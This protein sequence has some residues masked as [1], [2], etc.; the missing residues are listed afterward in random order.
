LALAPVAGN[1][2]DLDQALRIAEARS[3]QL[4]AQRAAFQAA[5][6]LVPA[7]G[8]N[9]DPRLV[10]G[11]E[12]V[13]AD[14]PDRGSLTADFMT[15]RRVGVMQDFVRS[16]KREA[17]EARAS[18]EALREAAM[19]D[20]QRSDLYRDVATAWF[21]KYYADRARALLDALDG[22]A[23]LQASTTQAELAAGKMAAGEALGAKILIASLADRRAESERK[24]RRAAASL[25]RWIEAEPA[26]PIG[27]APDIFSLPHHILA[28]RADLSLHPHIAVYAPIEAAA[29]AELTLARAA[30]KPDW[31]VELSYAQRGS[32]YTNMVTLM[33]R[34]DLPLFGSRRQDPVTL[35]KSRQLEQVRAQ[36]DDALRKHAAEVRVAAGDWEIAKSRVERHR[37]EIVPLVEERA[38]LARAAYEGGR[39]DL[40]SV[41]DARRGAIEARLAALDAEA[42]L[43]RAWAQ[44][45]YLV[46]ERSNP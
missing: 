11:V 43:A 4:A 27:K 40:A 10:F 35:S 18:A 19:I 28:P 34:M 23:Q 31:S 33:V 36:A 45:A 17:R 6:A 29:L 21:E 32:A 20:V 9:P 22:E 7:A 13:P 26:E 42:E 2:L 3:P 24:A 1:A 41:L 38:R 12:N 14:G 44:L 37:R 5:E 39:A 15:M 25:S 8:Q 46:P 16:E 30:T